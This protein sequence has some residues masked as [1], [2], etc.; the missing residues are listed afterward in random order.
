M[1]SDAPVG[2]PYNI[3]QYALL[4][5]MVAQVVDM[6]PG[7]FILS[8]GDLHIYSNQLEGV[9]EQLTRTPRP[10]PT[11]VLNPEVDDLFAFTLDDIKI[12]GYD[13]HPHIAYPVAV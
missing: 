8:S 4:L 3:A 7:N 10:L 9:K 11:L 1:S 5:A 13:P 6:D 2:K 12:E